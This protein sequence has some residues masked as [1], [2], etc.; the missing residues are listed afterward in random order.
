M[1]NLFFDLWKFQVM[2]QSLQIVL[3]SISLVKETFL[4]LLFPKQQFGTAETQKQAM[5]TLQEMA[6]AYMARLKQKKTG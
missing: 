1:I 2:N 5:N 4:K 6:I 3:L